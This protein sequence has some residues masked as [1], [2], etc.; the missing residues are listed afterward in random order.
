MNGQLERGLQKGPFQDRNNWPEIQKAQRKEPTRTGEEHADR[1]G[2]VKA[3]QAKLCFS[4][5]L[6]RQQQA[7]ED[8]SGAG[9]NN[10]R[11]C[12]SPIN[13]SCRGHAHFVFYSFVWKT[14]TKP[15]FS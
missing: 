7:T 15:F 12:R 1:E 5:Q 13:E 11:R 9:E 14:I 4:G 10:V 6:R 8:C 3:T 2:C